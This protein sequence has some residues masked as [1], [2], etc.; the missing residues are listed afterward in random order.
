MLKFVLKFYFARHYFSLLNTFMRKR[1]RSGARSV[2]L[3]NVSGSRRPKKHADPDPVPDPDLDPK[4][5]P[6]L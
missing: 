5:W 6:I 3:T 2:P 4:H 1:E